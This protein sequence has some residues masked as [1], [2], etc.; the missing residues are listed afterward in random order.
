RLV[1]AADSFMKTK[2]KVG[3]VVEGQREVERQA[4]IAA[5]ER[6]LVDRDRSVA[7]REGSGEREKTQ[8][9]RSVDGSSKFSRTGV[10]RKK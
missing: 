1:L 4:R 9:V 10:L 7:G 2:K 3:Q 6:K 8:R 5:L